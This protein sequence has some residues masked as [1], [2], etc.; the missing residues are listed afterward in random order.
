MNDKKEFQ[1]KLD[2]SRTLLK[3]IFSVYLEDS[4]FN[5][6]IDKCF[7]NENINI[8]EIYK[9]S[10]VIKINVYVKAYIYILRVIL[11]PKIKHSDLL[12]GI[13]QKISNLKLDF[14]DEDEFYEFAVKIKTD[15]NNL[16]N[17]IFT[18]ILNKF[19]ELSEK[20]ANLSQENINL[21]FENKNLENI[22]KE[23][24]Y[25]IIRSRDFIIKHNEIIEKLQINN[26]K[27][28]EVM[29][30]KYSMIIDENRKTINYLQSEIKKIDDYKYQLKRKSEEIMKK[31]KDEVNKNDY[32]IDKRLISNCII[33][34]FDRRNKDKK[35]QTLILETLAK[36]L[37]YN[38]EE[39]KIIG[40]SPITSKI[41]ECQSLNITS[42]K[43]REVSDNFLNFLTQV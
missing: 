28:V 29:N 6:S 10:K 22:E 9:L 24:Q 38:E 31:I 26:D 1:I 8:D 4:F 19:D 15:E 41:Q 42:N 23:F 14:E 13:Y 36:Y 39:R 33:K 25:E 16:L 7:P 3:N 35:I 11:A 40:L 20:N 18:D 30:K 17:K 21:K 32:L 34:I 27:N 37:D 43:I 5:K 12:N 2:N